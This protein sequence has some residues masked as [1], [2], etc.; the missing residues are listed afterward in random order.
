LFN[1]LG[2]V[3]RELGAAAA[4]YCRR[5]VESAELMEPGDLPDQLASGAIDTELDCDRKGVGRD[6]ISVLA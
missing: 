5:D 4:R 3:P 6:C 2:F 1:L